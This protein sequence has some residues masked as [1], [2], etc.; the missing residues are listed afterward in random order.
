[1]GTSRRLTENTQAPLAGAVVDRAAGVIRNVL[2]CGTESA[3]GR[4]YPVAVLRR[5]CAKYEGRPVN[6]DHAR[7]A[8]VARRAG[9][10]QNVRPGPDGRPRGDLH[11]LTTHRDYP[12]VME[13][14]ERN[15]ALF[16][17]SHV[18]YCQTATRNGREVV[19]A[20]ERV[21]SIDLV[22]DPATTKSLF[23]SRTMPTLKT[24]VESLVRHPGVPAATAL[25]LKRL[26]EMDGMGDVPMDAPVPPDGAPEPDTDEAVMAAFRSAIGAVVDRAMSGD[27]DPKAALGKIKELLR[28]HAGLNADGT[29]DGDGDPATTDADDA[30][31]EPKDEGR[32][33]VD[34]WLLLEECRA[35]SGPEFVPGRS[36][37]KALSLLTDAADR[38]ALLAEHRAATRAPAERPR[39]GRPAPRA[40]EPA[41]VPQGAREFAASV[42]D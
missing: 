1:M 18:A 22:A 31:G 21:E 38:R 25:R 26:S 11:L 9:W 27:L 36:L 15:P 32:R 40:G 41:A 7:E 35:E 13:A 16:G 10:V 3:N 39:S 30:A 19:E 37:L 42:R 5:D 24:F 34:P 33:P 28:S 12:A 2:L 23:E 17:L 6:F 14:A 8:T 4:D 29:P 20:I